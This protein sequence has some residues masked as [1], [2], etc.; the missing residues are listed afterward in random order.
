[1]AIEK[2]KDSLSIQKSSQASYALLTTYFLL[3]KYEEAEN[4][5]T[6]NI[7]VD[8]E[9]IDDLLS[10]CYEYGNLKENPKFYHKVLTEY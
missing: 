10:I 1:M 9:N 4:L 6:K 2:F 5:I 7:T 3:G 8:K